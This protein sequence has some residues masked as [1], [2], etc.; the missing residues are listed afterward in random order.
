M[1]LGDGARAAS[2]SALGG[3]MRHLV[4]GPFPPVPARRRTA[5][6]DRGRNGPSLR[7]GSSRPRTPSARPGPSRRRPRSQEVLGVPLHPQQTRRAGAA[8]RP[9]PLPPLRRRRPAR[10]PAPAAERES[11]AASQSYGRV[12]RG[13][14]R[15]TAGRS[16]ARR[17][18]GQPTSNGSS[19]VAM[20]SRWRTG[21][22]PSAVGEPAGERAL[23][24]ARVTVH[25]DQ[26]HRAAG[27]RHPRPAGPRRRAG[28]VPIRPAY[29][30]RIPR[31]RPPSGARRRRA[32]GPVV[33]TNKGEG[34]SA[35]DVLARGRVP[36]G[37]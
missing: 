9:V 34:E 19:C 1:G 6:T 26:P 35:R 2:A 37:Q 33:Q 36:R 15:A 8:A 24:G 23:A 7:G 5:G 17:G 11:G 28:I 18:G 10:P 20:S 31:G 16:P 22:P 27:G 3:H 13:P 12:P 14:G 25:G 30:R 4:P 29:V 32:A 21:A